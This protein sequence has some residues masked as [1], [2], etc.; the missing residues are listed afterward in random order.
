[1][2]ILQRGSKV[3]KLGKYNL[4]RTRSTLLPPAP[5]L[6]PGRWVAKLRKEMGWVKMPQKSTVFQSLFS[7]LSIHLVAVNLWQYSRIPV[8]IRL[9]LTLS[10][11][12]FSVS[13]GGWAPGVLYSAIF[14][15][16]T[17]NLDFLHENACLSIPPLSI[18]K[19]FFILLYQYSVPRIDLL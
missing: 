4:L 11:R 6:I 19:S 14:T 17:F 7:W 10:V 2:L 12:F 18:H 3:V 5:E 1:M 13:R 8:P 16:V 15:D 9:I